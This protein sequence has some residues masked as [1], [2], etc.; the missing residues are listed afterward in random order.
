MVGGKKQ[1]NFS[2]HLKTLLIL[3]PF[4]KLSETLRKRPKTLSADLHIPASKEGWTKK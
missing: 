1:K 4:R 2:S 3:N